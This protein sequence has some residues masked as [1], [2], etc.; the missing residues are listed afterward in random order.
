MLVLTRHEYYQKLIPTKLGNLTYDS[1]HDLSRWY[2]ITVT[3]GP[4][5]KTMAV[6]RPRED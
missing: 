3:I 2:E 4:D 5:G 1:V 6:W